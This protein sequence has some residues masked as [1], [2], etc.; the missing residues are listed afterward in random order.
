MRPKFACALALA[1]AASLML[2]FQAGAVTIVP[3]ADA[4]QGTAAAAAPGQPQT[5][6]QAGTSAAELA[7][8]RMQR[9]RERPQTCVQQGQESSP[10][11]SG[12][13]DDGDD[14]P[15]SRGNPR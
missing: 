9:C 10:S 12:M 1:V 2:A 5:S 4:V 7:R 14:K 3:A 15:G 8:R 11:P 13:A 6:G